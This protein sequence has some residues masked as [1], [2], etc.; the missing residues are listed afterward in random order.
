[1]RN[2]AE[3]HVVPVWDAYDRVIEPI[4]AHRPDVVYPPLAQYLSAPA[5]RGA[6][7]RT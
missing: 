2:I 3:V 4:R 1:M 7:N 6:P 5:F